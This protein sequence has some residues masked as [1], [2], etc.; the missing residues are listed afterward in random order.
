MILKFFTQQLCRQS[1]ATRAVIEKISHKVKIEEYN[2][3][4]EEG[5]AEAL[6]YNATKTPSIILL[7]HDGE[8]ITKFLGVVPEA[9]EL[10]KII[11]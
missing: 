4:T 6:F 1:P 9:K 10:E 8:I 11:T 5:L 2:I 3:S 7:N